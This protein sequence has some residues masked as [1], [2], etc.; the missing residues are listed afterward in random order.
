MS[1]TSDAHP[2]P[3]GA[4]EMLKCRG[5][6]AFDFIGNFANLHFLTIIIS[7]S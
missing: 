4:L 6:Y 7:D 3:T 2:I 1:C 5:L